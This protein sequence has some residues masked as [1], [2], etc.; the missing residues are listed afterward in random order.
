MEAHSCEASNIE[1][2][3]F[4]F[5]SILS[6]AGKSCFFPVAKRLAELKMLFRQLQNNASSSAESV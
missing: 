6:R 1:V 5:A 3:S 2:S 4:L